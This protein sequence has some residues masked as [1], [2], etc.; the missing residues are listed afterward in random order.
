VGFSRSAV[1]S[2]LRFRELWMINFMIESARFRISLTG[3]MS[4]FSGRESDGTASLA[5]TISDDRHIE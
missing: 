4:I 3:E 2:V 5:C 1:F